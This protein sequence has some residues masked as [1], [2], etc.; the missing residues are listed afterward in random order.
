MKKT[1]I[2]QIEVTREG[3]I[4]VRMRKQI[5]DGEETFDLGFHRT[6]VECGG[7]VEKQMEL[8]NQHLS[9]MGFAG[10]EANNVAEIRAHANV[11]FTP[12]RITAHKAKIEAMRKLANIAEET[13]HDPTPPKR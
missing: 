4:Q 12:S 13:A 1:I 8:V 7:D 3:H 10:I 5:I 9:G 11:A 2:D 6:I